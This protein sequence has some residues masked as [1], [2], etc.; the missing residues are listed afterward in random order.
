MSEPTTPDPKQILIP[1]C[2]HCNKELASLGMFH[3][4]MGPALILCLLCPECRKALHF[5]TAA[6][7]PEKSSIVAPS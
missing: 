1:L 5:E 6:L 2:P 7:M 3:W 4:S